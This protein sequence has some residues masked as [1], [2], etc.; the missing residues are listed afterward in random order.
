MVSEKR[1][2]N[3]V[4]DTPTT[5]TNKATKVLRHAAQPPRAPT[6]KRTHPTLRTATGDLLRCA[7]P[8]ARAAYKIPDPIARPAKSVIG[9]RRK[10]WSKTFTSER[11]GQSL[12]GGAVYPLARTKSPN[13]LR[14]PLLQVPTEII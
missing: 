10:V 1:I 11:R 6:C 3:R 5:S 7:F 2:N 9:R 8:R 13:Y 12:G 14:F 4:H